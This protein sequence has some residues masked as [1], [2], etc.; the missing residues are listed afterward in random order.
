MLCLK[1]G[2]VSWLLQRSDNYVFV[3]LAAELTLGGTPGRGN[4]F[5]GVIPLEIAN[6]AELEV[7]DLGP[8]VFQGTIHTEFGRL[9]KLR[10][11]VSGLHKQN[12]SGLSRPLT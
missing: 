6:L 2:I 3:H 5:S 7:L 11:F 10:K 1:I 8:S 9:Q 12:T 4:L